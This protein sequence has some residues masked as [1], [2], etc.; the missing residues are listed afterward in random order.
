[1][2]GVTLSPHEVRPRVLILIDTYPIGG[3]GKGLIQFLCNGGQT[4]CEPLMSGF[5]HDHLGPWRFREAVETTGCRF[6]A[7]RGASVWD[8]GVIRQALTLVRQNQIQVVQSHGYKAHLVCLALRLLTGTPWVAFV[9]GWTSENF[10]MRCYNWIDRSAVCVSDRVVTVSANLA[11]YVP[12]RGSARCKMITIPNAIEIPVASGERVAF[13]KRYGVATDELLALVVG[14]LSPEKG[15]LWFLDACARAVQEC[16]RLKI[17]F[18]GDGQER[19]RIVAASE[20]LG[21]A[22]RLILTGYQDQVSPF[23]E[24]SDFLVMPSFREG[25]PNAA[26]EAMAFGKPVLAS[27]VGGIPE[28]VVDGAT[29]LLVTSGDTAALAAALVTLGADATERERLG[30]AGLKRVREE[31]SPTVRVDR[32]ATVYRELLRP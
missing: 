31:F 9:H 16:R 29:G 28:V 26:L 14:R 15:H 6:A 13:R 11:Q 30:Q 3:P 19:D 1:M 17:M 5:Q 22:E 4:Q 27:R 25:M 10:K 8:P 7:L 32:I 23:Y 20:R 12:L 18:V 24:A 21:L 2:T